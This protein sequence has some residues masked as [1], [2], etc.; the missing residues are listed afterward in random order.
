[1]KLFLIPL[2]VCMLLVSGCTSTKNT[3]VTKPVLDEVV[4]AE[5]E[6]VAAP[7]EDEVS[8]L[9]DLTTIDISSNGTE[10]FWNFTAS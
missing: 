2:C 9:Y 3:E 5:V 6:Q 7:D 1:M 4:E 10:P 8:G